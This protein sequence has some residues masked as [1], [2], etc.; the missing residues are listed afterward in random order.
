M[1][2]T[3]QHQQDSPAAV[4]KNGKRQLTAIAVTVAI[5]WLTVLPAIGKIESVQSSIREREARGIDSGAM[6]YTD[7]DMMDGVLARS[8]QFHREHPRALWTIRVSPQVQEA[9]QA[10][11]SKAVPS[12]RF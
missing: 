6:F 8:K 4:A 5:I 10:S 11:R 12:G 3:P 1:S 9:P 7:L 2:P